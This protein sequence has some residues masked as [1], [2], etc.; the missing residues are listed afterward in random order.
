M[1]V[2]NVTEL[3]HRRRRKGRD[4]RVKIAAVASRAGRAYKLDQALPAQALVLVMI[5]IIGQIREAKTATVN[6]S[7]KDLAILFEVL[8]E[9]SATSGRHYFRILGPVLFTG[10]VLKVE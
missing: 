2:F 6:G 5:M 10:R 3:L 7:T 1:R 4:R 8:N 9:K